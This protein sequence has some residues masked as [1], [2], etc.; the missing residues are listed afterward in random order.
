MPPEEHP[1]PRDWLAKG[2]DLGALIRATDW[3]TTPLGPRDVWPQSLRTAVSLVVESKTPFAL[4]WGRELVFLYN[5]AYRDAGLSMRQ[6]VLGREAKELGAEVWNVRASTVASVMEHGESVVL[7]DTAV[8]L[9]R[10]GYLENAHVT[11][12]YSPIRQEDGTVGGILVGLTPPAARDRFDRQVSDQGLHE[13][14]ADLTR[15]QAMGHL[16]SW[17]WDLDSDRVT[18]SDELAHI[19]GLDSNDITPSMDALRER[20]HPADQPVHAANLALALSGKRVGPFEARVIRPNGEV[21]TILTSGIEVDVDAAG[22][23]SRVF[24]T[25]L[26][27]TERKQAEESLRLSEERFALALRAVEQVGIWDWN[28]END[29]VYYSPPLQEDARLRGGRGGEPLERVEAS[30]APR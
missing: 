27:I 20:L 3:S 28:W 11:V 15:A 22:K 25:L 23:P 13:R 14:E 29:T 21:R 10:R 17:R 26:D 19:F 16:G 7:E 8:T 18:W 4:L 24:C 1:L 2:G 9:A 12:T 5:D 30:R 6:G